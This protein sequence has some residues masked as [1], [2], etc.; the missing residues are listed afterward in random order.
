M[1]NAVKLALR[2]TTTTFDSEITSLINDCTTELEGM[3]V[4]VS[5]T[6]P[7]ILTAVISYCKWQFGENENADKWRE[8]YDRKLAQFQTMTNYTT[9]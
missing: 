3:G 1:L 5:T 2:V 4:T 7:Q 8:I 6:D 9:W